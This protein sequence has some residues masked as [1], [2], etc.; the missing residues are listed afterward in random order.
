MS[1][2][3]AD[4][5]EVPAVELRRG[6]DG[7]RLE[8]VERNG[9]DFILEARVSVRHCTAA[10]A[11]DASLDELTAWRARVASMYQTLAGRAVL[12]Q[13][14]FVVSMTAVSGGK[15]IVEGTFDSETGWGNGERAVLHFTLPPLDQTDLPGVIAMLDAATEMPQRDD[16]L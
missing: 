4:S 6:G 5:S 13:P 3:E 7:L 8:V 1:E 10:G 2:S 12:D 11:C 15:V 14:Q 9:D 16:D